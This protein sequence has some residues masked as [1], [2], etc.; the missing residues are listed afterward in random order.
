MQGLE[1]WLERNERQASGAPVA[2]FD[3]VEWED[4]GLVV[5]EHDLPAEQARQV[6]EDALLVHDLGARDG[7]AW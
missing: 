7:A 3:V 2:R 6:F 5:I 4:P 1:A